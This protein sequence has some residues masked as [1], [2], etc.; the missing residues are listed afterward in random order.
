MSTFSRERAH[1]TRVSVNKKVAG[2]N[3]Q[4]YLLQKF[5]CRWV[6]CQPWNLGLSERV[7]QERLLKE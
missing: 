5:H 1:L 3:S 6:A 2:W 7:E 4:Q